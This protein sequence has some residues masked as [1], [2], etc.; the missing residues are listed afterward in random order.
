MELVNSPKYHYNPY[1]RQIIKHTVHGEVHHSI[2][3]HEGEEAEVEGGIDL[4]TI[5]GYHSKG[6]WREW[7]EPYKPHPQALDPQLLWE[8]VN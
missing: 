5:S 4:T 3:D 2:L 7:R 1:K 8:S 6:G